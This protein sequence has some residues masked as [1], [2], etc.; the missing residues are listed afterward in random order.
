MPYMCYVVLGTLR[1]PNEQVQNASCIIAV[2]AFGRVRSEAMGAKNEL[3]HH[4][5]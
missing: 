4:F 5:L 2:A 1:V 3:C